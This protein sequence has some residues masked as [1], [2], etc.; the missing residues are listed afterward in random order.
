MNDWFDEGHFAKNVYGH[1]FDP[2]EVYARHR[3]GVADE[4]IFRDTYKVDEVP[5]L[6]KAFEPKA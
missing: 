3:A 5:D 4:Q 1:E 2:D 6:S